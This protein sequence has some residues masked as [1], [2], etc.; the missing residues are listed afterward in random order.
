MTS[1]RPFRGCAKEAIAST[2]WAHT[3]ASARPGTVRTRPIRSVKVSDS[4]LVPHG[5]P[6]K[7]AVVDV[8]IHLRHRSRFNINSIFTYGHALL[9]CVMVMRFI[10]IHMQYTVC[11]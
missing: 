2:P 8:G 6:Q 3:N 7:Q 10:K 9:G 5:Y 1:A 4:E 11:T